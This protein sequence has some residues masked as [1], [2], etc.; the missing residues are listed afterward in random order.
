MWQIKPG[1]G[2]TGHIVY[3][4]V[5]AF[6]TFIFAPVFFIVLIFYPEVYKTAVYAN[7]SEEDDD[8]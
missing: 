6:T 7:L 1:F 2:K 3:L 8:K 5:I 4:G